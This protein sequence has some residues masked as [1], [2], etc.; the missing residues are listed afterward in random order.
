MSELTFGERISDV[1]TKLKI[2]GKVAF[3]I[4]PG[5]RFAFGTEVIRGVPLRVWKS[6]PPNI[7]DYYKQ[8]FQKFADR[9][10]LVYQDQRITF[11]DAHRMYEAIGAE[12][13]ENP[14]FNVQKGDRVGIAMRNYPEFLISFLAIS[15]AGGVAV[16]LN[17]LWG[18]SELEYAVSDAA[19]TV[20]ITDPER[21]AL[22]LPFQK[23]V[24][25]KV[26][27]V[28]GDVNTV[29]AASASGAI[30]WNE[31]LSN[32]ISRLRENPSAPQRRRDMIVP[33][34]EA[35][36]MY[37]SGSTGFPKGVVH[38]HRS[39]GTSMKVGELA[40]V[41]VPDPNGVQLMAVP[42]FHIT[43][44]CAV[45]L[46]SIPSG[47]KI[48]MMRK[49]E[50]GKGLE[51]IEKEH[52][53]R[54]TG[55][56]TMMQDLM[57]HPAWDEKKVSSLKS[58]VAGG[59]PVPPSQVTEMRE[60]SK[61]IDSTQ[62]YGLTESMAIGTVN[63]G[64]DYL[65]HPTSCGRPIPIICD[66][67]II[68]PDTKLKVP[69]GQ[70]GE[71]CLRG[72]FIMKGYNNLPEKTAEAIDKDGYFH[73]G[74]IGKME[75]GFVYILDRLKDLIIRGGENI[76]CSEVERAFVTHPAARECSV[77]ALPDERLGEVVG[78]AVWVTDPS[79][80]PAELRAHAAKS[81][82]KFKVP[83]IDNIFFHHEA[84]PKGYTGKLDKKGM[85]AHYSE[86]VSKRPKKSRL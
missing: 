51:I 79:C 53:T 49:W 28:R 83:D 26:I 43:A 62:G 41:V 47:T 77:F 52:V 23:K 7:G 1:W 74:D 42:L 12:L 24:G 20:L 14:H 44:L 32:G 6:L 72:A 36:I 55:V 57:R 61:Q 16:P 65:M 8:W 18:S 30:S 71:V 64:A 35:M 86:I 76:D 85:R 60:K 84:L 3:N 38:T 37:T 78:A 66:L 69:D 40:T 11:G 17:A 82:A 46:F 2:V 58:V 63:K 45:G 68:D 21:L 50:A 81:L 5:G 15:A 27:M 31:V 33:E 54:V 34:D 80:T 59:A 19:C 10:W 70:R 4:I 25:F 22:C 56:P 67:A 73:T 39:V 9:E 13:F 48:I 75:G 29:P